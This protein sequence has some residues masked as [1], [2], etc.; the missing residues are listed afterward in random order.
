MICSAQMT[1]SAIAHSKLLAS[2]FA[3]LEDAFALLAFAA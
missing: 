2:E 1:A 3:Y